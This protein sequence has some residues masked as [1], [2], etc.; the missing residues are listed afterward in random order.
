MHLRTHLFLFALHPDVAFLPVAEM[1][2]RLHLRK[3]RK[4]CTTAVRMDDWRR[5]TRRTAQVG[6]RG[7]G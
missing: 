1:R 4:S 7:R 2:G 6:W 3:L 5:C